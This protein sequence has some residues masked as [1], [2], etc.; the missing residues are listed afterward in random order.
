MIKPALHHVTFKT[1][2][3]AEM[4]AWYQAVIGAEVNFRDPGAAW[5]TNDAANHRI[6][7]LAIPGLAD[8]PAKSGHTGMHHTAFEYASFADLITSFDRLRQA[9]IEPAFCLD[10]GLTVSIYYRDPDGNFV[11]LQCDS[12]SDWK[13]STAWMRT[14]PDFAANPIGTFFDPARVLERHLAGE[15]FERLHADMRGGTYLP[16]PLPQIM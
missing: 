1:T 14:S 8:D 9:K 11:E 13:Q 3:L 10:H 12:Y 16:N 5:L 15:T 2:R 6:A 4:I 7:F